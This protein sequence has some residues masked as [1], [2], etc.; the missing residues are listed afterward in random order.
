MVDN[1]PKTLTILGVTG[2]I[3]SST[4]RIVRAYPERF[5]VAVMTAQDNV[6][7]LIALVHEF[8]PTLAVIGNAAHYATLKEAVAG[9]GVQVAAG[10]AAL[11]DAAR[12]PSDMVIAAIVGTAGLAPVMAAVQRGATVALAN[13][14]ALVAAGDL[15]MAEAARCGATLLPIDSEH[16]AIFQIYH[17]R[18]AAYLDKITLTASGGPLRT[19]DAAAIATVTPQQAVAHPNWS[20]GAKISVDSATLM[21]KGLELMEA[22]HLFA[23]PA[24][25]LDVVVHPQS[26]IHGLAHYHDGSVL[27][28]MGLPDMITPIAVCLAYPQRVALPIPKLDLA[29]IARLDFEAPDMVRFPCLALALDA[30]RRGGGAPTILNAAN[31]VAVA[32]F[33]RC[34]CGFMD[35]PR[36]IEQALNALHAEA[37]L[38]LSALEDVLALDARARIAA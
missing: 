8:K 4:L 31:E 21:N 3:G 13:K 5:S 38:N 37:A 1:A 26:I 28:Q 30:M 22:K 10:E 14:E 12:A 19:W 24:D 34:E 35:I 20:M 15:V 2:S 6:E 23:L 16:N 11:A 25:K 18:D 7:A 9:L 32:K 29:A 17:A 33:L 27:A 36:H